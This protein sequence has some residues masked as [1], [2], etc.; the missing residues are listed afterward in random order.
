MDTTDDEEQVLTK[1]HID[2][3]KPY[4]SASVPIDTDKPSPI[5]KVPVVDTRAPV[6]IVTR[7]P[8]DEQKNTIPTHYYYIFSSAKVPASLLS[9]SVPRKL[10]PVKTD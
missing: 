1:D 2:A 5:S 8:I 3:D 9:I 10:S 7:V 4:H 6:E